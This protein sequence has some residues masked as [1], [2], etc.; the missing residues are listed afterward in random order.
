MAT[1]KPATNNTLRIHQVEE[2]SGYKRPT[3]YKKMK[4]G[5]FPQNFP[6]GSRAVGWLE[7]EVLEWREKQINK[8]VKA[9]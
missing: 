2:L 7:S 4:L 5:E 9:A 3:I 8:R 1:D 6:L